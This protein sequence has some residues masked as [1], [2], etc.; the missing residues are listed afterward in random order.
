[1]AN[2]PAPAPAPAPTPGAGASGGVPAV[3]VIPDL[4]PGYPKLGWQMGLVP[5]MAMFRRFASLNAQ[6]LL[7]MQSELIHLEN[8]LRDME[9][10]SSRSTEGHGSKYACD[11]YF[12]YM[13]NSAKDDPQHALILKIKERLK[14]FSKCSALGGGGVG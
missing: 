8:E 6:I 7:Y 5:E 1:M 14:E 10:A 9:Q 12:L 2:A 3:V 4:I 11:A 13:A